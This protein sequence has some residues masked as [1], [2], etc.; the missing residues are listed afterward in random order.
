VLSAERTHR[1]AARFDAAHEVAH[2]ILHPDEAPGS[3]AVERQ[4][5]AFA[6]ELLAP[7][8]ELADLLP[9]RADWKQLLDLK[10]VWGISIQAL[11]Y[12][13][14]SLQVMSEHTYRRAVTELNARGWRTQEPLDDGRAEEPLLLGKALD[15]AENHGVS[16]EALAS[17]ARLPIETVQAIANVHAMPLLEI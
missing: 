1:A 11:L 3:H 5:N 2:L 4:A 7:S 6:A 12:R 16:R 17:Q 10:A 15:L 14:K 8:S 13:A 9:S